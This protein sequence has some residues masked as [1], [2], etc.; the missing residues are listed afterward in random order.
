MKNFNAYSD[1]IEVRKLMDSKLHLL[2]VAYVTDQPLSTLERLS[3]EI[4]ALSASESN[5]IKA[6]LG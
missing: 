4:S 6:W 3:G 5:A 2:M 1:V